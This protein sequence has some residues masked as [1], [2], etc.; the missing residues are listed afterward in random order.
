MTSQISGRA[1]GWYSING[2]DRF[3][4]HLSVTLSQHHILCE[5]LRWDLFGQILSKL[6]IFAIV[7]AVGAAGY[8][9]STVRT[10]RSLS[11]HVVVLC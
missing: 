4:C 8:A 2:H 5:E 11:L 6:Y 9:A 10:N 7:V 1:R 3:E